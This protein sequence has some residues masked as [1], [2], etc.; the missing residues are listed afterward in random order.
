M[1]CYQSWITD[2]LLKKRSRNVNSRAIHFSK[3]LN[4]I[5]FMIYT[6]NVTQTILLLKHVVEYCY[7]FEKFSYCFRKQLK[8]K[9]HQTAINRFPKFQLLLST[10]IIQ[11]NFI[12][13]VEIRK[14][15][16]WFF[17]YVTCGRP[18]LKKKNTHTC[19][20][21]SLE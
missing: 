13:K 3:L 16:F 20:F 15:L 14:S 6:F 18:E 19:D 5:D 4:L 8:M 21:F 9:F 12:S 7:I 1:I 11:T 2:G 17:V 10:V